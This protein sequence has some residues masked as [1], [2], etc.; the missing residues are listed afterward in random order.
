MRLIFDP[1]LFYI[2]QGVS[3]QPITIENSIRICYKLFLHYYRADIL[4]IIVFYNHLQ[5]VN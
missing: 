5:G 1:F 3:A 2:Y 4:P